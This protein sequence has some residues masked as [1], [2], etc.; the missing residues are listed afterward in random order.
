MNPNRFLLLCVISCA[1]AVSLSSRGIAFAQ[2]DDLDFGDGMEAT[3]NKTSISSED[4]EV[5]SELEAEE[6]L[7]MPKAQVQQEETPILEPLEEPVSK[8]PSAEEP[9]KQF[10]S[11]PRAIETMANDEPDLNYEARL[12]DIYI[13]FYKAKTPQAEWDALLGSK[14]AESYYIQKGDNL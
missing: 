3:D 4:A 2:D 8:E 13:N 1:L 5:E 9:E 11:E 12:N 7:A 14:E 10:A 6:N